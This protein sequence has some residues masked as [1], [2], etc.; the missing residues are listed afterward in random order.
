M[1]EI[2]FSSFNINDFCGWNKDTHAEAIKSWGE[3]EGELT[4]F[5]IADSDTSK[6]RIALWELIR[7]VLGK[8]TPNYAQLRGDCVSFGAKN[9]MEALQCVQIALGQRQEFKLIFPPYIYGISRVQIG[10]GQLWGDGSNGVWAAKGV[11]KYGVLSSEA[12]GCPKYSSEVAGEWGKS[13]PPE[14]FITIG[15][16][17]LVKSTAPIK[18]WQDAIT[19]LSNGYP[20]TIASDYGFDMTPRSDGFNHHSTSWG[21]Q[22]CLLMIDQGGDGVEPHAGILNSWGDVHGK[23]T[24]FRTKVDWPV[25][26]L[27]VRKQDIEGILESGDCWAFSNFDGFPAQ[28][29]PESYF[30]ML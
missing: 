1:N 12:K 22:M 29:L 8:D 7:K 10:G 4:S 11:M 5:Y 3:D 19:A 9:A 20:V 6:Q 27:R 28:K 25:G 30:D 17:H 18:T 15:K 16:E 26:T 23:I 13:G 21:H 2:D 14:E 24:D